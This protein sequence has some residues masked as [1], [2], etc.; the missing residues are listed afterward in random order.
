M[1][2]VNH[3]N[4]LYSIALML[5]SKATL[6]KVPISETTQ[7]KSTELVYGNQKAKPT[8]DQLKQ[9]MAAGVDVFKLLTGKLQKEEHLFGKKSKSLTSGESLSCRTL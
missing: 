7:N 3:V 5:L 9:E 4:I 1:S 8:T 6:L 2:D